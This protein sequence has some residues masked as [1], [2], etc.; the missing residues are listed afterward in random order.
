VTDHDG[1][2]VRSPPTEPHTTG[3]LALF[4]LSAAASVAL[5]FVYWYGGQPQWEGALLAV[6]LGGFGGA[7]VLWANRFIEHGPF[8]Q[9]RHEPETSE[10]ARDVVEQEFERGV[11]RRK[12]L[13]GGFGTAAAALLGALV[14]P[15][16]SLG[17]APG[18]AL[19]TTPWRRGRRAITADGAAVRASDVPTGSIVTVFPQGFPG[20][21][22]GQAL[23]VRVDPALLHGDARQDAV[24]GILCFSKV[25]PHAGCPVG[26]YQ[27]NR[28][29]LLC[30]C[31][32]ST[33]DVL[34]RGKPTFGPAARP[35]PRLPI[36]ID[37]EG[38]IV[39]TGDFP[40]PIGPT[41]WFRP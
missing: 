5:G 4:L 29:E 12:V 28:H 37:A 39:A 3:V 16:R 13:L 15:I 24:Q 41:W 26:L 14:F 17:P 36:E 32:Q 21:A 33:F 38:F 11:T 6:S 2:D 1:G 34:D 10:A 27:A 25:C 22:D 40:E 8:E 19:T 31:H 20:S 30:P 23:L 9:S 35:L 7:L 18:N